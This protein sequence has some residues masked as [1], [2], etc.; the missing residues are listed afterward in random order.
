M[1]VPYVW[2]VRGCGQ[3]MTLEASHYRLKPG[4]RVLQFASS[5]AG[6]YVEAGCLCYVHSAACSCLKVSAT[7]VLGAH[8]RWVV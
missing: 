5:K 3:S 6:A 4:W 1:G 7:A 8:N 2:S